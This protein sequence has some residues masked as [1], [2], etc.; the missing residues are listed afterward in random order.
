MDAFQGTRMHCPG[1]EMLPLLLFSGD[2]KFDGGCSNSFDWEINISY[3]PL[4]GSS[5]IHSS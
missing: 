4:H 2:Y 3:L 1:K 5:N